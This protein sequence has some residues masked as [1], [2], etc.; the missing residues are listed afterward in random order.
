[1]SEMFN[2]LKQ[3]LVLNM[4]KTIIPIAEQSHSNA[5][6]TI[7]ELLDKA[8]HNILDK[9]GLLPP[10]NIDINTKYYEKNEE[11]DYMIELVNKSI[12]D[13]IQFEK[14]KVELSIDKSKLKHLRYESFETCTKFMSYKQSLKDNGIDINVYK[15]NSEHNTIEFKLLKKYVD[16]FH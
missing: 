13:A 11:C 1:M 16:V 15:N 10:K 12:S 7:K 3:Y 14:E 2:T 5:N 6:P 4:N 8:T 9:K